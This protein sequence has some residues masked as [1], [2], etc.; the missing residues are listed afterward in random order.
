MEYVIITLIIVIIL[1]TYG[2]HN[3][4]IKYEI[5]EDEVLESDTFIET[6]ITPIQSAYL[7][8]KA[9][10]R[11]GSFE[12]DDE[13]GFIFKEIKSTMELLNKRLNLD[14]KEEKE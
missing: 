14:G 4:M 2:I 11:I 6:I 1:L 12:S 9:I 10:D 3:L 5:L 7:R 13:A 8:M